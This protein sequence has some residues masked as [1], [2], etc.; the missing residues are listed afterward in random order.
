MSQQPNSQRDHITLRNAVISCIMENPVGRDKLLEILS[1]YD[2]CGAENDIFYAPLLKMELQQ[3]SL[4][5]LDTKHRE[6]YKTLRSDIQSILGEEIQKMNELLSTQQ[7][8]FRS[9]FRRLL[10]LH[11]ETFLIRVL[12]YAAAIIVCAFIGIGAFGF[13][14]LFV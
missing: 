14:K 4:E 11:R 9:Q 12:I 3:R 1:S 7:V 10:A 6:F 5:M 2:N 13:Y 8:I